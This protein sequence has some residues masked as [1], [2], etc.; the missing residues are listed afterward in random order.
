M[1]EQIEAFERNDDKEAGDDG[2]RRVAREEAEEVEGGQSFGK[3]VSEG[4]IVPGNSLG[5]TVGLGGALG[6]KVNRQ[7]DAVRALVGRNSVLNIL[8]RGSTH[9]FAE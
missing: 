4:G 6:V 3:R 1:V 5:S 7:E 9:D 2:T 8:M